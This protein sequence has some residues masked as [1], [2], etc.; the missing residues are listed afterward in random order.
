MRSEAPSAPRDTPPRLS[1]TLL[2][3]TAPRLPPKESSSR[4]SLA[5][6]DG[7]QPGHLRR[8]IHGVDPPEEDLERSLVGVMRV[9]VTQ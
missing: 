5:L 9:V 3:L 7:A 1:T 8:R 4:P 2:P 6:P